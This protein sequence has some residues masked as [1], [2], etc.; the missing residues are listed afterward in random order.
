MGR[1]N[2][3][4]IA[5]DDLAQP[6]RIFYERLNPGEEER[7]KKLVDNLAEF[8]RPRMKEGPY[9]KGF[10]IA[11]V[12]GILRFLD[13]RIAQDVD[14]AV[15]GLKYTANLVRERNHPFE[16]VKLFT[17]TL[18]G[19][20]ERLNTNVIAE[21]G[22]SG[23]T[24]EVRGGSGSFSRLDVEYDFA[25]GERSLASLRSELE[26]FDWWGSKGLQ[27]AFKGLR[28]I[29]IQFV[30]NQTPEEWMANQATLQE[31]PTKRGRPV[32]PDF[33]YAV[34]HQE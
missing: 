15:V 29:D 25:K 30:F 22:V 1:F 34:L 14:L 33:P 16:D 5:E 31:I 21:L 3:P 26:S 13:P 6:P 23:Q 11:G 10:L 8:M 32:S 28:P 24:V 4:A 19:Y 17:E 12:G 7:V 18:H 2:F 20:F 27:L 9:R